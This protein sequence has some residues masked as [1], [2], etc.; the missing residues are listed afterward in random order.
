MSYSR[1]SS[2]KWYTF[3]STDGGKLKDEQTFE[4]MID[5]ARSIRFTYKELKEDRDYCII[6]VIDL[7]K[8]SKDYKFLKEV[9]TESGQD[10][11]F[12]Y[13]KRIADPFPI[14]NEDL[15]EL[16]K[17]MRQFIKDVEWEYGILGRASNALCK[18]PKPFNNLGYWL[19]IKTTPS[20]I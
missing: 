9:Q 8:N 5:L 20:R 6:Q 10:T 4:I 19:W 7:C 14:I 2:S 17:Y 18:L 3:W 16:E 1:W 12:I 11:K 15:V 13:E